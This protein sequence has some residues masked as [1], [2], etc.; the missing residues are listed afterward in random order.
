MTRMLFDSQ[1]GPGRA[2]TVS[3]GHVR[4][5]DRDF[6][7]R[8]LAGVHQTG[9][10]RHEGLHHF[11]LFDEVSPAIFSASGAGKVSI[12]SSRLSDSL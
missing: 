6:G 4:R 10:G 7:Q 3:P 8:A 11:L 12:R 1:H 9:D 2:H 5:R